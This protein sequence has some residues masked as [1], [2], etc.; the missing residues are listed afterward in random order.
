MRLRGSPCQRGR[1]QRPFSE[2]PRTAR[3]SARSGARRPGQAVEPAFEVVEG[4]RLL[5][6]VED[7]AK[8]EP[9]AV[10]Q[11][12]RADANAAGSVGTGSAVGASVGVAAATGEAVGATGEAVCATGEAVGTT[13]GA[14]GTTGDAFA[15]PPHPTTTK[16]RSATSI[17]RI[18]EA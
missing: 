5:A 1:G 10:L 11:G 16:A 2:G 14:V 8:G 6:R 3:A 13:G 7:Q 4:N 15:L 9:V 12:D 18:A 17:L